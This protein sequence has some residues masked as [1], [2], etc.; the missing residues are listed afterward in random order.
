MLAGQL[1]LHGVALGDQM[2]LALRPA[3]SRAADRR[4]DRAVAGATRAAAGV[5]I[6]RAGLVGRVMADRLFL[7]A[8][9]A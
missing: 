2:A 5:D 3:R 7:Y 9:A 4:P 6:A 8:I 1:G